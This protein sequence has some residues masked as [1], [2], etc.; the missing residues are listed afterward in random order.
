MGEPV[1]EKMEIDESF[2][3]SKKHGKLVHLRILAPKRIWLGFPFLGVLPSLVPISAVFVI[4][5]FG[6]CLDD[7]KK[8]IKIM[9]NK[10]KN[11]KK[12]SRYK[13][14][15]AKEHS[16]YVS[17]DFLAYCPYSSQVLWSTLI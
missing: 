1:L 7:E 14:N 4:F 17:L 3:F 9:K 8:I 10:L 11:Q 5:W 6:I 13:R 16:L 12:L 2:S 15:W